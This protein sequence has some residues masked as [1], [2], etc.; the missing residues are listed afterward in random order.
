MYARRVRA[1]VNRSAWSMTPRRASSQRARP[2]KDRQP[3]R[4]GRRPPGGPQPVRA[5]AP[6]GSGPGMPP[7]AAPLEAAELVKAAAGL[8]Y[9]ERVVVAAGLDVHAP[10]DRVADMVA[11]VGVLERDRRARRLAR[12]GVERNPD[13]AAVPHPGAEVRVEPGADADRANQRVRVR[14]DGELVD[15]P[16]P[17][18]RLREDR[19]A[20]RRRHAE[21]GGGAGKDDDER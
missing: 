10:R 4:V 17:H 1:A 8:V 5:Q 15:A 12:D 6:H 16:V 3:G 9:Q 7:P 18:V 20:R 14:S 11:L 19:T 13:R 21:G 2:G